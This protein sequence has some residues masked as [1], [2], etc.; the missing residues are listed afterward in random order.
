MAQKKK[1]NNVVTN[2]LNFGNITKEKAKEELVKCARNPQYFIENYC[3]IQHKQRGLIPFK[4]YDFQKDV[5]LKFRQNEFIIVNKSR[6]VGM[7]TLSAGYVTW[8]ILFQSDKKVLIMAQKQSGAVELLEKVKLMY[9]QLPEWMKAI[10]TIIGDNAL[11]LILSNRSKVTATATTKEAG[12]SAAVSL[13]IIDEAAF[14]ET[15]EDTWTAISPTIT[16]GK[17]EDYVFN[18]V[19]CLIL[20]TPNG[21]GNFFHNTF[22]RAEAQQNDFYPI[23]L[24]WYCVPEYTEEWFENEKRN[25]GDPRKVAQEYECSFIGSGHTV[26]S[27]DDIE[28]MKK[29]AKQPMMTSGIGSSLWIW[30]DYTIGHKYILS[31]DVARGDGADYSTFMI[32]D[33]NSSN[34]V[35]EYQSKVTTDKFASTLVSVAKQYGNALIIVENAGPGWA[36]LDGIKN[37]RYDNVF[38]GKKNGLVPNE[39]ADPTFA[40][41]DSDCVIGFTVSG[42]NREV[43]IS[44]LEEVIRTKQINF[45]SKRFA[46]ELDTF[47]YRN[48][49]PEA[50]KG[51]NDDLCMC[52]AILSWVYTYSFA[53]YKGTSESS[54][55]ENIPLISVS[56]TIV[57]VQAPGQKELPPIPG[58][59]YS[60]M[61][62]NGAVLIRVG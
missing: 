53:K 61:K 27:S 16:S 25:L 14:V 21:V 30:E 54:I 12:R 8:F 9:G 17:G 32:L 29:N 44:K 60:R 47:I 10:S 58:D 59:S 23:T 52:A 7:S 36:V 4:L 28:T 18:G 57:K 19:R 56:R 43:I 40:K 24:P 45:F 37:L 34:V 11:S 13:L 20:S 35:C 50:T 3:K 6:Q 41:Y 1:P 38:Y 5:V 51:A 48:G 2:K 33:C 26:V 22:V 39:F 62:Y 15:M 55:G 42:R 31:A 49:R 46:N